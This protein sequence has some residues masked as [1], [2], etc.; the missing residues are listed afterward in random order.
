MLL[1]KDL[2]TSNENSKVQ[3]AV[4]STGSRNGQKRRFSLHV[5]FLP[6]QSLS[7]RSFLEIPVPPQKLP[8]GPL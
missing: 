5:L 7:F 6:P 1:W 2:L 3:G 4:H 8:G